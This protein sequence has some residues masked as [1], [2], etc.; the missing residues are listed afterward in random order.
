MADA[1]NGRCIFWHAL[2]GR[3]CFWWTCIKWQTCIKTCF[4]WKSVFLE[5]RA[6]NGRCVKWQ[7]HEMADMHRDMLWMADSAPGKDF[8]VVAVWRPSVLISSYCAAQHKKVAQP[9]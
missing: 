6:S 9:K 8:G 4:G 1:S 5:R 3:Q 7:M 2:D